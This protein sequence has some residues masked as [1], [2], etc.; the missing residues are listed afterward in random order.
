[1]VAFS[2][3]FFGAR[4]GVIKWTLLSPSMTQP[5]LS[6]STS[7]SQWLTS[8]SALFLPSSHSPLREVKG[9]QTVI[10]LA[11]GVSAHNASMFPFPV[12]LD[13]LWLVDIVW[14]PWWCVFFFLFLSGSVCLSCEWWRNGTEYLWCRLKCYFILLYYILFC[15][16][17]L[18]LGTLNNLKSWHMG[19][20]SGSV[21]CLSELLFLS[22][23]CTAKSCFVV[24]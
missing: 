5:R 20:A 3:F 12:A 19:F 17:Y 4:R 14:S 8:P 1:V 2:P 23:L 21:S 10:R 24:L 16:F 11:A 9:A 18:I 15:L 6:Y 7:Q 22:Q 13:F